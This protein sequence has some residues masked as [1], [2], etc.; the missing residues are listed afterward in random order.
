MAHT[1]LLTGATGMIGQALI[2]LLARRNDVRAIFALTHTS[3]YMGS[4]C[5]VT[6]VRGDVT[7]GPAL[8]ITPESTSEILDRTNVIVHAAADTRFSASLDEARSVNLDGTKN[9]LAFASHCPRLQAFASLSTVHVAGKRTGTICEED[10]DHTSGF[11]NSYEQ[12]KYEAELLL[13]ESMS[14]LPISV[15][16][17]STVLG[18]STTGEVGQMAAIHHALRLYYNS[19]APMIPGEPESLVDLIATE[20]AATAV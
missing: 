1:V 8:G 10:L 14:A 16:R 4:S 15:L 5:K 20:Y 11:V 12:S 19:L 2:P 13:R 9:L 17:L 6:P 7:A 18:S 3:E